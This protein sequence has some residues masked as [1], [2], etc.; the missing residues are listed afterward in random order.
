MEN[1]KI[2]FDLRG[3]S[4]DQKRLEGPVSILSPTRM[5]EVEKALRLT[6]AL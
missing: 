3:R 6:L 1:W 5:R 2:P 4:L